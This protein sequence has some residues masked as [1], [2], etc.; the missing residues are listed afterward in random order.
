MLEAAIALQLSNLPDAVALDANGEGLM[1]EKEI[2][3]VGEFENK[4]AGI[5][6]SLSQ[7]DLDHFAETHKKMV[8]NGVDVPMP[9]EHTTDPEKRRATCLELRRRKNETGLEAL[10]SVMK[11]RDKEAAKLAKS[12]NVSIYVPPEFTDGKG[13]TYKRPITHIA[14]TDYPVIPH[15]GKFAAIAASLVIEDSKKGKTMS[16]AALAGKL[17]IKADG[18]DD[19][20]LETEILAFIKKLQDDLKA[21]KEPPEEKKE[22]K[23]EPE[24][25]AA[26]FVNLMKDNRRMK[27]DALVTSGHISPAQRTAAESYLKDEVVSLACSHG[28]NCDGF[29]TFCNVAGKAEPRKY[30]EKS[31]AQGGVPIAASLSDVKQ[32]PMLAAAQARADAADAAA[33]HRRR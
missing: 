32:N 30:G 21:A 20:A 13:N 18:K 11:F 2:A 17:E 19:A 7:A 12:T 26:G 10:Y 24:K 1:F 29:E 4:P 6:F 8:E 3:Y 28:G 31:G 5:K 15:L 22:E 9:L 33:A 27:L 25:I 23:K 14:F 16:L